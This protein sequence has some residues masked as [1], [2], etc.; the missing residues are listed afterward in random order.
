MLKRQGRIRPGLG[1]G[2]VALLLLPVVQGCG[3][4]PEPTWTS[5]AERLEFPAAQGRKA[6]SLPWREGRGAELVTEDGGVTLR[7]PLR[8]ED[9]KL[10]RRRGFWQVPIEL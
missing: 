1:S 7:V 6:T 5:L 3:S 2:R 10:A 8:R 4:A 9:W